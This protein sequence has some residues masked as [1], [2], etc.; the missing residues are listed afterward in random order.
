MRVVVVFKR[1]ALDGIKL[2]IYLLNSRGFAAYYAGCSVAYGV[3]SAGVED[4]FKKV[5]FSC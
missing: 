2:N 3:R 4:Y 1:P 5:C